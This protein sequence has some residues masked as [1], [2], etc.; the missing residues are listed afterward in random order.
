MLI[1]L[2]FIP[3]KPKQTP[4][5]KTPNRR[6]EK[7]NQ[8][9]STQVQPRRSKPKGTNHVPKPPKKKKKKRKS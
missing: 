1:L 9:E 4:L 3:M 2:N 7:K 5:N 6:R 8:R